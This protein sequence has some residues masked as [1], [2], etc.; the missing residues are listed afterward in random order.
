[1]KKIAGHEI[2]ISYPIFNERFIIHTED[3][4]TQHGGVISQNGRHSTFY[5]RKITPAQINYTNTEE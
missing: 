1:M 5:S 3:R 2:L 4:K